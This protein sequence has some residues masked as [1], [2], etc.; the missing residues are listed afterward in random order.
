[1]Y[2]VYFLSC[3]D[4]K[5]YLGCT[6]NLKERFEKH[7]KGLVGATKSRLPVSLIAVI[8]IRNKYSAFNLEKYF[9][10]GSGRAFL[11]KHKILE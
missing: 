10:S 8:S 9:K 2:H 3:K 1:M 6:N 5:T 11:K 7:K 4:K